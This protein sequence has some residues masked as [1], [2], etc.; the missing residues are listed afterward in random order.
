MRQKQAES[1]TEAREALDALEANLRP[2]LRMQAAAIDVWVA[3]GTELVSEYRATAARLADVD[4]VLIPPQRGREL[5][6][7]Q[8]FDRLTTIDQ[9]VEESLARVGVLAHIVLHALARD[10]SQ[11]GTHGRG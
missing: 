7:P 8:L 4:A 3:T 1:A 11:T 2:V 6:L 9:S 5:H 10:P